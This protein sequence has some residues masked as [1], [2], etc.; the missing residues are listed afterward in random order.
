MIS[1]RGF[2]VFIRVRLASLKPRRLGVFSPN[3]AD[4]AHDLT[5]DWVRDPTRKR[6]FAVASPASY[7]LLSVLDEADVLASCNVTKQMEI[8]SSVCLCL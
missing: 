5:H 2:H 6:G 3:V 8:L 1:G 7:L 4:L